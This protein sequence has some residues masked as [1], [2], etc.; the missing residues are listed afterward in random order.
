VEEDNEQAD[1][2]EGQE[3]VGG[4]EKPEAI[5]KGREQSDMQDLTSFT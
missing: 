3:G 1:P 2:E 4:V 5:E